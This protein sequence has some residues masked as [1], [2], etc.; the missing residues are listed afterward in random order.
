MDEFGVLT[1]QYGLKPQG[2]SAPMAASKRPTS[3]N[4]TQAWNFGVDS[5]SNP[6][7]SSYS[8]RSPPANSNSD[9]A[10]FFD[11]QDVLFQSGSNDKTRSFGGL[12]DY[13]DIFGGPDAYDVFG[14]MPGLKSPGSGK[15]N[16]KG[17]DIFGSFASAPKQSATVDD[18]LGDLSGVRQKL[19]TLNVKNDK[20]VNRSAKVGKNGGDFDDL[21]PGFGGSA[22]SNNGTY[23]QENHRQQSTIHST[24]SNFS[25]SLDDPFVVLE[26]VS[27]SISTPAY[28]SSDIFSELEQ[29]SKF[30]NSGG[31]KLGVSSNSSTKLKSPPKSAQVSKGDKERSSGVSSIDELEEFAKG[32]VRNNATGRTNVRSH[33]GVETSATRRGRSSEDDLMGF[34][35]NSVPRSRAAPATLDPV[36]DAPT[37]NRGGPR[38]QGTS[39]TS[40]SMKKSSSATG[41]FDDL[42]SMNGASPGFVEFEEVEG[43]SEERR[44]ARLGRHQRAHERALQ[45]V[46]DM[47]QRDRKTQQEQEEKRVLWPESGWETVSLT[48]LITSGS[49]KKV[50]RKATLCIHPDKVQ[51]KGASLEQKYTAEKVFDILKEAWNKFNKEELS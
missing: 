11:A 29:I 43:E 37:N 12:D 49:V 16:A 1:E 39:G 31:A 18:L 42:F 44:R 26:S 51:Q 48:D 23:A 4:N 24:K 27:T 3:A 33:E 50:Y 35:S 10:S 9:Y 13:D 46:A 20:N 19:Q 5:N 22:P 47:N 6:K 38:P 28:D 25:S 40:S 14:G 15:S 17:D 7:T 45:A 32:T 2:K 21:I 41:I 8:S 36:F 34:R 30:S